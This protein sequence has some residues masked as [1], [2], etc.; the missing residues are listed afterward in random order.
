MVK[1]WLPHTGSAAQGCLEKIVTGRA[2]ALTRH[3]SAKIVRDMVLAVIKM[4]DN[5]LT[6]TLALQQQMPAGKK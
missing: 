3:N 4:R 6:S 5:E 1:A 2:T